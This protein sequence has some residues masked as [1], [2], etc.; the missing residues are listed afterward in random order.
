MYPKYVIQ[1][2]NMEHCCFIIKKFLLQALP[3]RRSFDPTGAGDTFAG[4]LRVITDENIW[5]KHEN[6]IIQVLI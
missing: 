5:K 2:R 3:I 1:E 6:A 4:G